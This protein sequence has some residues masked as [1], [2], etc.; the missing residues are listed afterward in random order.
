MPLNI[1]ACYLFT[2]STLCGYVPKLSIY[3][4]FILHVLTGVLE[5]VTLKGLLA[6]IKMFEFVN[7]DY[8][9]L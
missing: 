5:I 3:Y 9:K 8:T 7:I 2:I 1:N 6:I 4:F